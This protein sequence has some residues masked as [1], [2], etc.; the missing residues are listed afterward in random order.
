MHAAVNGITQL[1]RSAYSEPSVKS[2][3]FMSSI[4]TIITSQ[5]PYHFTEKDWNI[6]SQEIVVAK[7]KE[8]PSL[9]I[10]AA[11]K[12]AAERAFWKFRDDK[13]PHFTMTTV[14]PV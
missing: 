10:Y 2:F 7:G 11:S 5:R 14:N 13:K 8:A 12:T 4:L 6:E 1:L 9:A 3:V